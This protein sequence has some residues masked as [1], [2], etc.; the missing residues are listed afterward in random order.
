MPSN[1]TDDSEEIQQTL[2]SPPGIV[3]FAGL[4]GSHGTSQG[5]KASIS[6]LET[7]DVQGTERW[8]QGNT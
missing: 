1:G 3:W 6:M 5:L 2:G 8:P 7:H 4:S